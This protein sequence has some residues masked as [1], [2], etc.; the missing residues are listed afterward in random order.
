M[1]PQ[2]LGDRRAI[3]DDQ[4]FERT[5]E[6]PQKHRKDELDI[7]LCRTATPMYLHRVP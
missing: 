3:I 7:L 4:D 1:G 2:V 6:P 5:P